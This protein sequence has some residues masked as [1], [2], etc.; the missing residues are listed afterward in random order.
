MMKNLLIY[1]LTMAAF[2]TAKAQTISNVN[3]DQIKADLNSN[4]PN[5]YNTLLSRLRAK[6]TTLTPDNYAHLY[7]GQ[8]FQPAYSPYGAQLKANLAMKRVSQGDLPG[9]ERA[10]DSCLMAD[11]VSMDALYD[12]AYLVFQQGRRAEMPLYGIPFRGVLRVILQSGDGKTDKTAMV[13]THVSDEYQ[14]IK[15]FKLKLKSQALTPSKC[16]LMTFED[17]PQGI[18]QLYFNVEKPLAQGF[19]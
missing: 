1:L 3:F 5:N 15:Y 12:K 2:A 14:V 11:P 17:N 19:K 6:D 7:Y 16:D 4:G 9:A 13:V 18:T 8:V 10:I